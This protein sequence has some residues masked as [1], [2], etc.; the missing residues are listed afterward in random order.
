MFF[1]LKSILLS[2]TFWVVF[3]A[4]II[5]WMLENSQRH[6]VVLFVFFPLLAAFSRFFVSQS[7]VGVVAFYSTL[8]NF[9]FMCWYVFL[10]SKI[11]LVDIDATYIFGEFLYFHLGID[12]LSATF[13]FLTNLLFMLAVLLSYY[14]VQKNCRFYFSLLFFLE[15][16]IIGTFVARDILL[17]YIFFEIVLLPMLLIIGIWGSR[18]RRIYAMYKFVLYTLFGSFLMLFAIIYMYLVTGTTNIMVLQMFHF[19]E[20]ESICLWLALFIAFAVKVPMFPFHSWLPEAHV[21]ASTVGSVILAGILLK[22]GG[23]G[24]FRFN[25]SMFNYGLEFFKPMVLTMCVISVLY[26]SLLAIVQIDIKKFVAYSSIAHMNLAIAGMFIDSSLGLI[27][28]VFSMLS[29]GITSSGLFICVGELYGRYGSRYIGYYGGL[30]SFMPFFS[31]FFFIFV[32]GNMAVP[33]TSAFVGELF[34]YM[35][36]SSSNLILAIFMLPQIVLTASYSIWFFNRIIYGNRVLPRNNVT[37]IPTYDR[38]LN[39]TVDFDYREITIMFILMFYLL[40]FGFFPNVLIQYLI[41]E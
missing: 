9:L 2:I 24:L 13:I 40:S 34:L 14:S 6:L 31:F 26:A 38:T 32:I 12:R 33:G 11:G 37:E 20:L 3:G 39:V 5:E 16:A 35:A 19:T 10:T 4:S 41:G 15:F 36:M 17:F 21:E 1:N 8:N 30:S 23:Y 25:I 29:H 28:S 27:G 18:P 7:R 22:L